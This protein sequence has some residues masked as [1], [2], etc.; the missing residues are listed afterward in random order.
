[1]GP[2][3][4]MGRGRPSNP[5]RRG[6]ANHDLGPAWIPPQRQA[7]RRIVRVIWALAP[8]RIH[9]FIVRVVLSLVTVL[10]LALAAAL[11]LDRLMAAGEPDLD[12]G[13]AF[14]W[15]GDRGIV[16]AGRVI[17]VLAVAIAGRP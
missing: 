6:T 10:G 4:D 14:A 17:F 2:E 5:V 13:K 8:S 1:M 16:L 3:Q 9:W 12:V 15:F 7:G 11:A